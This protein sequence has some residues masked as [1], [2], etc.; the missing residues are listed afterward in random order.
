MVP[1]IGQEVVVEHL[2]GN[3]DL[4]VITGRVN[5][6]S[7]QP[8]S[9]SKI[10]ALPGNQALAGIRSKEHHGNRYNQLLFDDTK[11]EIRTQLESEHANTPT[12][13]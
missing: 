10:G 6:Q 9:F 4:P 2:H 12:R 11:G 1:R 8:P 7:Q 5:N 13:S 3:P